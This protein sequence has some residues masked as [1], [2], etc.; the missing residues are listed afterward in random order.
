MPPIGSD[1]AKVFSGDTVT[2]RLSS[3]RGSDAIAISAVRLEPGGT[4]LVQ[5]VEAVG[6]DLDVAFEAP[7]RGLGEVKSV[8]VVSRWPVGFAVATAE[9]NVGHPLQVFPQYWADRGLTSPGSATGL[10][11]SRRRGM[12]EQPF[13]LRE[14]RTGD[15]QRRIHWPTTARTGSLMVAEP[16]AELDTHQSFTIA[17]T[18]GATAEAL[19]LA[20]SI[21]A[22]LCAGASQAGAGFSLAG[23]GPRPL[24]TWG[25]AHAALVAWSGRPGSGAGGEHRTRVEATA[26]AVVVRRGSEEYACRSEPPSWRRSAS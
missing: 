8:R 6:D 13:G 11:E 4:V 5:S 20:V 25:A 26:A 12:G 24:Q 22:S 17:A 23:A 21:A 3:N 18:A 7:P 9:L 19:E 16:E 15:S 1:L 10:A 2:L 14:Y